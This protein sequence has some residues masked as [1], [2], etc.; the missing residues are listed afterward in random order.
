MENKRAGKNI[1][2]VFYS[3]KKNSLKEYVYSL[4]LLWITIGY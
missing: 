1:N 2:P 4:C 3:I